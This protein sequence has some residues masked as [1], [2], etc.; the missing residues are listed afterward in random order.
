VTVCPYCALTHTAKC[1]LVKAFEY[2]E[3]GAIKRVEFMTITDSMPQPFFPPP[4]PDRPFG[5]F[6]TTCETQKTPE[7]E[8]PGVPNSPA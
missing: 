5:P 2:Y 8:A 3:N 6:A 4:L 7:A 1:H